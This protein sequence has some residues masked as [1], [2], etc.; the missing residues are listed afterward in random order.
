MKSWAGMGLGRALMVWKRRG[1]RMV[2]A[3]MVMCL[4]YI[5]EFLGG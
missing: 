4:V 2:R 3:V 5:V 1:E